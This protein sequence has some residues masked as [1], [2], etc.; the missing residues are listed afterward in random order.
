MIW[1]TKRRDF[2]I[3]HVVDMCEAGLSYEGALLMGSLTEFIELLKGEEAAELNAD[4]RS[5]QKRLRY[6]LPN[7]AAITLY[8]LGFSDRVIALDLAPLLASTNQHRKDAIKA[9]KRK[10]ADAQA[11]IQEYPS[12]FQERLNEILST[13]RSS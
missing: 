2:K 10:K 4:I 1:G 5:F 3:D 12:Y 6:G 13:K 8:E 9:L 11:I 7:D